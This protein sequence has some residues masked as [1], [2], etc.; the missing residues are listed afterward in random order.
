MLAVLGEEQGDQGG[1]TGCWERKAV[2]EG[3][4]GG[5]LQIARRASAFSLSEAAAVRGSG[6]DLRFHRPPPFWLL[7][8]HGTFEGRVRN[9]VL[10]VSWVCGVPAWPG[11]NRWC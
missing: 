11:G 10:V 8:D 4:D 2:G 7:C 6:A 3:G 9:R 5:A 1:W